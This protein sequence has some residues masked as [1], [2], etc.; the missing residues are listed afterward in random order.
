MDG[1]GP[2]LA[3]EAV[4][5]LLPWAAQVQAAERFNIGLAAVEDW[6]LA[7]GIL[8][9]RYARNRQTLS[10]QQQLTLC[11]SAV[12]VVGCGGLGGY[13][14]EQLARLGVGRIV[15]ID[16]DCFEEHNLNRQI[17]SSPANLGEAKVDIARRRVA[18]INPAVVLVAI[19]AAF[20]PGREDM[21]DG[22]GVVADGLDTIAG[23]LDLARTCR[24]LGLALVH[25][26]IAGWYGQIA[27]EYA[28]APVL[29]RLYA[30]G[31]EGGAERRLGNPAFTPAVIASLQVAEICKILLGLDGRLRGRAIRVDLLDM[32]FDDINL[33][34]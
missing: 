34:D 18:S 21:L 6:A 31:G 16:P 17:L 7:A 13:L 27:V 29:E 32:S 26:A 28:D 24:R 12:A 30:Q 33:A 8:P 25:G 3:S 22:V 23:R 1:L 20:A 9:A 2:F 19:R 15:A 11:R 10:V 4:D 14:I 5:G